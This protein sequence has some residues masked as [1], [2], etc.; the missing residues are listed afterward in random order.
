MIIDV[1][2]QT[3]ALIDSPV[4]PG[5]ESQT[6]IGRSVVSM[7]HLALTDFK[8][9]VKRN[10]KHKSIVAAFASSG[11]ATGFAGS[12]WGKKIAA[13]KAK[14]NQTD[15]D[16]FEAKLKAQEVAKKVAKAIKA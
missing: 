10:A 5:L 9:P 2:D 6:G 3:R 11:A 16:R 14:A 4:V 7:K 8:I 1:V 13:K 15:F 12:A